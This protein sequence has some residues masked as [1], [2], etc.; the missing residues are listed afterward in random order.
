MLSRFS[1]HSVSCPRN[2]PYMRS[3]LLLPS[4]NLNPWGR[5]FVSLT[6]T[7]PLNLT[8]AYLRI[9]LAPSKAS[10]ELFTCSLCS[11]VSSHLHT[12]TF[13]NKMEWIIV[14]GITS[15]HLVLLTNR[16]DLD[17]CQIRDVWE[18]E[19]ENYQLSTFCYLHPGRFRRGIWTPQY[20]AR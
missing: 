14:L 7:K 8:R 1:S 17:I 3:M 13:M 16:T 5:L 10:T 18:P 6:I 4:I 19:M 15:N 2:K 11:P 12:I 20:F 9:S